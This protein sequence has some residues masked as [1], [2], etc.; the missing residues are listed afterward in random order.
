MVLC[1]EVPRLRRHPVSPNQRVRLGLAGS[2]KPSRNGFLQSRMH[3]EMCRKL[4]RPGLSYTGIQD[5]KALPPGAIRRHCMDRKSN[6][7]TVCRLPGYTLLT[8]VG[9]TTLEPLCVSA[10]Y[11]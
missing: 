5:S 10:I 9:L 3:I 2:L 1:S 4:L 11:S 7:I 6:A 8:R